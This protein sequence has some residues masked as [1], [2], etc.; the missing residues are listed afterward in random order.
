MSS[1]A[2]ADAP[3][4]SIVIPTRNRRT[5]LAE[6]IAS[7]SAQTL[8]D[9]ELIVVDDCSEDDTAS[10][11]SGLDDRR[12][13]L[14]RLDRH[15]E[16]SAARNT[17]LD[18]ARGELIL[19]LDDDDLLIDSGLQ[20]HSD[21]FTRHPSAI[22]AV[23]SVE[24]F[25]ERGASSSSRLVRRRQLRD[26]WPD[27]LLGWGP[28]CGRSVFRTSAMKSVQGWNSTYSIC[29]DHE[30]WL[31]LSPLGP[32]VLLPEIVYRYRIHS[33]QW[34]P[35]KP[36]MQKLLVAMREEAVR[37]LDGSTRRRA[38]QILAAREQYRLAMRQYRGDQP[39]RA[40]LSFLNVVR[41]FPPILK[42]PLMGRRLRRRMMR[43]LVGGR[44][45]VKWWRRRFGGG[46][47]DYSVRSIQHS[48]KGRVNV[49][50]AGPASWQN[51]DDE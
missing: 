34:R 11:V 49:G 15:A 7:I 48:S 31:R 30:L 50:D 44:P 25:D 40:L 28:V 20:T 45:V 33:G 17:G 29:E 27:V 19:F 14:V 47:I 23:G 1:T 16:R 38:E 41:L 4:F 51:D 46:T 2:I 37:Q 36:Q 42:S 10:Y 22:A 39:F 43:C 26:V 5:L 13:R 8:G 21:A 12:I 9:W 24:Q 35:P 32:V 3:R 6:A 18:L